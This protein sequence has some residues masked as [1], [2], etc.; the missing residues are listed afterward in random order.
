[1]SVTIVAVVA[2]ATTLVVGNV[3]LVFL[4]ERVPNIMQQIMQIGSA[5]VTT[6]NPPIIPPIAPP[7]P[8]MNGKHKQRCDIKITQ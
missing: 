4:A 6:T 2:V 8:V 3:L 1:M 5:T 7:R